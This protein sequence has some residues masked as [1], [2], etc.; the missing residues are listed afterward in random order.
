MIDALK[1]K[2]TF[3]KI[4]SKW[5]GALTSNDVMISARLLQRTQLP[6]ET[7]ALQVQLV[8]PASLYIGI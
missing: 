8:Q 6:K 5:V 2:V 1:T 3:T 4:D 7:Q